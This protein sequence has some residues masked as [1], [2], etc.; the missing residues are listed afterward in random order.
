[1]A[2]LSGNP[3]PANTSPAWSLAAFVGALFQL[4]LREQLDAQTAGDKSDA[5]YAWG[6]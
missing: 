3:A 1:M 4:E 2:T 5:A 6:L